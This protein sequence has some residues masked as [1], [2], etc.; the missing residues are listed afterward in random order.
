METK[1]SMARLWELAESEHGR[2]SRSVVSA[3]CYLILRR[4][5]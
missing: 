4:Q 5:G 3:V 1:R 2:L